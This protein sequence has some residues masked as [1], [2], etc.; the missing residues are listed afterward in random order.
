MEG[1]CRGEPGDFLKSMLH[2]KREEGTYP[3]DAD[4]R[5]S[6]QTSKGQQLPNLVMYMI[7]IC[8]H[9][10]QGSGI[11]WSLILFLALFSSF[12]LFIVP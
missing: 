5:M 12:A 11:D 7:Q 10:H 8:L 3:D 6:V 2:F 4:G 1:H 9:L